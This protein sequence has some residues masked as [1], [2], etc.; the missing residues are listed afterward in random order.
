M[1]MKNYWIALFL[2]VSLVANAQQKPTFY[3]IRVKDQ[4]TWLIK[5][6]ERQA[7]TI[8]LEDL[9]LGKSTLSNAQISE[10]KLIQEDLYVELGL[11]NEQSIVG[12]LQDFQSASIQILTE[13]TGLLDISRSQ[14]KSIQRIEKEQ[15]QGGTY[16]FPNPHPTRYFFGPSAIPLKKGEK[17]FQ[18]AYILANSMQ[19]GLTDHLSIGGGVVIPFLFFVTPKIGYQVSEHVHVG[20]GILLANSFINDLNLGV[21]VAYGSLT[22]GSREHNVTL[23]A[24]WGATKQNS[25]DPVSYQSSSSW[26][27]ADKPMFTLSGMTRISKRCMLITENWFFS[28]KDYRYDSMGNTNGTKSITN[29]IMSGG[30]RIMWKK[31]SLDAGIL[32]HIGVGSPAMGIPYLDY[33]IKF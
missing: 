23:N 33:V 10:E 21:G 31:T 30:V 22:L 15:I 6:L 32:S 12:I 26:G 8:T 18:N 13:K 16:V 27:M 25:Y 3:S 9:I 11:V 28:V 24:G 2:F 17:Y 5:I 29:G 14:I 1:G 7:Q 20:G 19:V 4:G